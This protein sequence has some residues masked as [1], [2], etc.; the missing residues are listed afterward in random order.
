VG[1]VTEG[2]VGGV[3]ALRAG[4]REWLNL[5]GKKGVRESVFLSE[6]ALG[7]GDGEGC[8]PSVG[9]CGGRDSGALETGWLRR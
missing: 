9:F 3:E 8:F 7:L 1:V 5:R 2:E 4:A 6:Q